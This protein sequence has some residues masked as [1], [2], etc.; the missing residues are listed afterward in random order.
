VTAEVTHF[1]PPRTWGVHGIDGPIRA[2]VNVTVDPVAGNARSR[3]TI[4]I[5]FHRHGIGRVLLPLVVRREAQYEMPSNLERPK[6]RLER[7]YPAPGAGLRGISDSRVGRRHRRSPPRSERRLPRWRAGEDLTRTRDDDRARRQTPG[8]AR[9]RRTQRE[10]ASPVRD[11]RPSS[12]PAVRTSG[13]QT[14]PIRRWR[15][16]CCARDADIGSG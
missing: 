16:A 3:L 14:P 13:T 9:F 11:A 6:A 10:R 15:A 8:D 2:S 1:D 4:E 12:I 5:D 7:P